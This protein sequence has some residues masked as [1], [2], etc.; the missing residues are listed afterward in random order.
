MR[1]VAEAWEV[2][3]I[4]ILHF[5]CLIVVQF[6]LVRTGTVSNPSSKCQGS[7][8]AAGHVNCAGNYVYGC[9]CLLVILVLMW[10]TT[11]RRELPSMVNYNQSYS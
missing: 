3:Y 2:G 5:C 7:T 6:L 8:G 9:M 11:T 4:T 1:T 10:Y